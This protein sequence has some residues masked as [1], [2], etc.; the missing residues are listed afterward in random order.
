MNHSKIMPYLNPYKITIGQWINKIKSGETCI[1]TN[2]NAMILLKH[3]AEFEPGIEV[4]TKDEC[5]KI[6]IKKK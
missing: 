3:I 6:V 2:D 4:T 1:M 5:G